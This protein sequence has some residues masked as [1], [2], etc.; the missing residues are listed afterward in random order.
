MMRGWGTT[1]ALYAAVKFSLVRNWS[2]L[3]TNITVPWTLW[4][5]KKE[6]HSKRAGHGISLQSSL[7][8]SNERLDIHGVLLL[9]LI[10]LLNSVI[11]QNRSILSPVANSAEIALS[12]L[13]FVRRAILYS[14]LPALTADL[15]YST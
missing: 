9:L 10:L 6:K 11:R 8:K 2:G 3:W 4:D 5:A 7:H 15:Y 14:M 1:R 12:N 13:L